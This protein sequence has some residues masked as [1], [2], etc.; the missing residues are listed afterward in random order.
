MKEKLSP[1]FQELLVSVGQE[2]VYGQGSALIEQL[3]RIPC[4][5]MQIHRQ[6]NKHGKA[7]AK[8]LEAASPQQASQRVYAML[9]G[10]MVLT[11]E[12][13]WKEVKIGR[14]FSEQTH[15]RCPEKRNWIKHS[16][17]VAHLGCHQEFEG[18]MSTL[19]DKYEG[20]ADE[21]VFIN[22][23][24]KWIWNWIASSYPKARQILDFFHAKAHLSTFSALYFRTKTQHQDWLK[25]Q[26]ELLISKG[27]SALIQVL[28]ELPYRTAS[29]EKEKTKLVQYYKNNEH[30]MNYPVYLEKGLLIGSG[31]MEAAHRTVSQKR[32]K[33][34]G[35]H[36][37]INGAQNVLNLRVLN[38][39]GKWAELQNMLKAA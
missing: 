24:A 4:N 1:Y 21:L 30:R 35:Q 33:L 6:T 9:D 12:E 2:E 20:L 31:P 11:R 26:S 15:I 5:S 14:V 28:E 3:L 29:L 13:G 7:V 23:G 32:L 8:A 39:S 16:E 27:G 37:T 10:S 38:L 19:T 36:W 25:A 18:K 22:D 34:S 17:Y